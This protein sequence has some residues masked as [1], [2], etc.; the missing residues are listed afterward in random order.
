MIPPSPSSNKSHH[1]A[2]ARTVL[3]IDDQPEIRTLVQAVLVD[4]G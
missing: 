4:A 1:G 3:V 2:V